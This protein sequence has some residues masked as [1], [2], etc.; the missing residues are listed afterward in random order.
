MKRCLIC[1]TYYDLQRNC[2]SC[3]AFPAKLGGFDAYAPDLAYGGG[4]FKPSY[5]AELARLEESNFWFC[6]RNKIILWALKKYAPRFTSFLEIGCGTGYVL[7]GVAK[8]FPNASLQG[9]EIFVEGLSFASQRLPCVNL[10]QMDA[11]AIPF[12]EEFDVVGAFDVLE[13]IKEDDVVLR[14]IHRALKPQGIIILTVPQHTWLWSAA[15]EYA[16]HER[17]YASN[18]ILS[19]V[20]AAGFYALKSTSFI[21]TL[22]PAMMAS[23]FSKK[24]VGEK[25]DLT[26]ELKISPILNFT[27]ARILDL[28][29]SAIKL[30]INLP[31]GG[32]RLVVCQKI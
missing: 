4:G 19:K 1:N 5:F 25:Y 3:G 6:A 15:D 14:E 8:N 30:G 22:L 12:C 9:S 32:S 29:I 17:R 16:C 2:P 21:T 28:E 13:H 23:R 18:E 31:V 27:F 26:A 11:R 7:S 20:K 24:H 10:M